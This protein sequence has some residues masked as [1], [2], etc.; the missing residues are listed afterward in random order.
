MVSALFREEMGLQLCIG[1]G[2]GLLSSPKVQSGSEARPGL[3]LPGGKAV[4][5]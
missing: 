3:I 1:E 5:T 2:K 4:G